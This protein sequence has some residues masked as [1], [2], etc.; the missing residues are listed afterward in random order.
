MCKSDDGDDKTTV[1]NEIVSCLTSSTVSSSSNFNKLN[2]PAKLHLILTS[3]EYNDI[4]CWL[5]HGR[6]WRVQQQER[7]ELEVLPKFF[8]HKKLAS[9]ARQVTGWGFHRVSSGPDF[10][11]YYHELFLR[12][13]PERSHT[14]KRPTRT[15]LS[16]RKRTLSKTSPDFYAMPPAHNDSTAPGNVAW[17]PTSALAM[18]DEEYSD[19]LE[20]RLSTY[21]PTEKGLYLS[22]E[23]NRLGK[24]RAKILETLREMDVS[25][26]TTHQLTSSSSSVMPLCNRLLTTIPLARYRYPLPHFL[27]RLQK[28][29]TITTEKHNLVIKSLATRKGYPI[30]THLGNVFGSDGRTQDQGYSQVVGWWSQ[31][32]WKSGFA[33]SPKT[34]MTSILQ[35]DTLWETYGRWLPY[36]YLIE[37]IVLLLL[38][39]LMLMLEV[40]TIFSLLHTLPAMKRRLL[41]AASICVIRKWWGYFQTHSY[42]DDTRTNVLTT[43]KIPSCWWL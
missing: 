38:L 11:A 22:L 1:S 8:R 5:P 15:E 21:S 37:S 41:T 10:N 12:D 23:L 30:N 14:M 27:A 29:S 2:F 32:H 42:R 3:P 35:R 9:F 6:A 36:Q 13:A 19:M 7:L 31:S 17:D 24:K 25:T 33:L 20:M 16:E 28:P 39:M 34:T 43:R 26:H 4:I 18:T 40:K